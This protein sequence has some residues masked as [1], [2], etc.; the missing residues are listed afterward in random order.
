MK[1]E[2]WNQ[3]VVDLIRLKKNDKSDDEI[4]NILDIIEISKEMIRENVDWNS[5]ITYRNRRKKYREE[6]RKDI[7]RR[8]CKKRGLGFIPLNDW[9]ED[10]HAHH[11]DKERIIYIPAKLHNSVF[12]NLDTGKGMNYIND[13]AIDFLYTQ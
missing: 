1:K 4:N 2:D 6:H 12:H 8:S 10:S 9:F 11:I 5:F 13:L 7:Q 3:I